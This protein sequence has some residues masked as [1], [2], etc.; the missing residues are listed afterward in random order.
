MVQQDFLTL[1]LGFDVESLELDELL[2][3]RFSRKSLKN[4]YE[5]KRFHQGFFLHI[6]FDLGN[7][8]GG[9]IWAAIFSMFVE[10]FLCNFWGTSWS[11]WTSNRLILYFM[12]DLINFLSEVHQSC[13]F[14]Q[15]LCL[16]NKLYNY[17]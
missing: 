16:F 12:I 9:W 8:W 7:F 1:I 17:Y 14:Y 10:R 5:L 6:L 15:N 2:L 11:C 13:L 3:W 4:L